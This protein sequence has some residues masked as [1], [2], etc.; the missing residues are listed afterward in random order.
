MD[1]D[2]H[3]NLQL[4]NSELSEE[5]YQTLIANLSGIVYRC[6]GDR[7]MEFL[8]GSVLEL[9]GF[10]S[11]EFINNQNRSWTSIIYPEDR[12]I[13]QRIISESLIC[14]QPYSLEYRIIDAQEDI[15]WFCDKGRGV[16][17]EDHQLLWLDGAIF[18]IS[19]RKQFEI[20]L[21]ERVHLSI[22][23]AEIGS[24]SIYTGT[25]E[26]LIQTS[27]E[28]L[29][30]HLPINFAHVWTINTLGNGLD[31]QASA[32]Q[33]NS[34]DSDRLRNL[35]GKDKLLFIAQGIFQSLASDQILASLTPSDQLWLERKGIMAIEGYPL[36]VKERVIG[37]MF[38]ASQTHLDTD[39]RLIDNI[40][41]AIALA[42]DRKQSEEKLKR[43]T[44]MA[45]SANKARSLF[46]A[47]MSHEL[48]TPLNSILG[49]T[50]L[51]LRDI[52]PE[53]SHHSYLKIIHNSAGHL[54][55]LINDV[56]DMSKIESGR[57][58]LNHND[59][60]LYQFLD[61]L[62]KMF[63]L[64]AN[65][66]ALQ[67]NF[68]RSPQVPQWINT[69]EPKLRQILI[70]LLSNAIKFT[71]RGAVTLAVEVNNLQIDNL[72]TT[73]ADQI[74][75]I[76]VVEDTGEGI[77]DNELERIFEPF[78]QTA[79]GR[80]A[81]EG[82]GLGLS[83]S[84]KFA[85]LMGGKITVSSILGKGSIFEVNLPIIK[86]I[87]TPVSRP[88]QIFNNSFSET[89]NR[90]IIGLAPNQPEFRILVVEDRW[91]SRHLLVK[92]LESV[93]FQIREAENGAE[94]I[95]IWEEWQPHL[96]WMDIRMPVMDGYEATRQ[97]K[98]SLKGQDTVIIALTA[99]ALEEEKTLMLS[100]GCDD[101][102]R[103]PFRA[104]L[105][106]DKLADYL[107]VIY[108][109]ESKNYNYDDIDQK[110]I[111]LNVLASNLQVSLPER[112]YSWTAQLYQ[113]A[114]L[115]DND[116]MFELIK[117]IP[118]SNIVLSQTLISLMDNFCYNQ[119]MNIAKQSL[120]N[121]RNLNM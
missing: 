72:Q 50:Q 8:G 83:I 69:D 57:I 79:L 46:L 95:A 28:S 61:D 56:L 21:L 88:D 20:E 33:F 23:L 76:F 92:L 10:Q 96:I 66:Q 39:I 85:Q 65:T 31:S 59:F 119:I 38:L 105:I 78:V 101:F 51:I 73:T 32:G 67:L 107:G 25:L 68:K 22:L 102:V 36:M 82:T 42:I 49:F 5:N 37:V 81:S 90:Q 64:K 15:H 109:Y 9:T 114:M 48:R 30:R 40:C 120:E 44:K 54:L 115:A 93:G 34:S 89:Q 12:E 97:I 24:A 103:K 113:A 71:N 94:A 41:N 1:I 91:E 116:L 80:K 13:V 4:S 6:A 70:N 17:T 55:G 19:D 7:T 47:N 117:D 110:P 58:S 75:L 84:S 35:I 53:N 26:E 98:T 3:P 77:P 104:S 45:E 112:P 52:T 99:S 106:F 87:N 108:L 43:S 14:R 27:V 18:D 121:N 11:K 74:N 100:A 2:H 60:D 86:L 63:Y 62:E 29:W 16:F 118:S 111:D